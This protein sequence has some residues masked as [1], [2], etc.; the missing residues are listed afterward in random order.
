MTNFVARA[1]AES[2]ETH[3]KRVGPGRGTHASPHAANARA[4]SFDP[5]DLL[6]QDIA[7]GIEAPRQDFVPDRPCRAP[8]STRGFFDVMGSFPAP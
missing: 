3:E 6:T 7:S 5:L 4:A 2:H 1:D 8:R